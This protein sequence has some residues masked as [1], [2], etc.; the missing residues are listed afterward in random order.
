M[1]EAGHHGK[2]HKNFRDW[3]GPKAGQSLP[4][5]PEEPASSAVDS[6]KNTK[7]VQVTGD[8]LQQ[9]TELPTERIE[10]QSVQM[11][12]SE[13]AH[14]ATATTIDP[15]ELPT[16]L[17]S[18]QPR[19]G[20]ALGVDEP[21]PEPTSQSINP[22]VAQYGLSDTSES[23]HVVRVKGADELDEDASGSQSYAA[24]DRA[25][26]AQ[27]QIDCPHN[28]GVPQMVMGSTFLAL[29]ED[30]VP[31]NDSQTNQPP[32][33]EVVAPESVLQRALWL[34]ND[35]LQDAFDEYPRIMR[36]ICLGYAISIAGGGVVVA[37]QIKEGKIQVTQQTAEASTPKKPEPQPLPT[38]QSSAAPDYRNL[39]M[40]GPGEGVSHAIARQQAWREKAGLPIDPEPLSTIV[41]RLT[42]QLDRQTTSVA[43]V[44]V[45]QPNAT[46]VWA[47]YDETG[48]VVG[49]DIFPAGEA[50][51]V[52][53][54]DTRGQLELHENHNDSQPAVAVSLS[55]D[56]IQQPPADAPQPQTITSSPPAPPTAPQ[57]SNWFK[58]AWDW[59]SS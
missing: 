51:L 5:L 54:K 31:R 22:R 59:F 42:V 4:L 52:P 47:N 21:T 9:N 33:A 16:E 44:W 23:A 24:I 10:L 55:I 58:R 19:N 56:S 27:N 50:T 1:T 38:A 6:N 49:V 8:V 25:E 12:A 28:L 13:S 46:H 35:R 26:Q 30:P 14:Q 40:V 43:D 17:T 37:R 32:S 41:Q 7:P 36:A 18:V 2:R 48:H 34:V 20:G 39:T 53:V 3:F 15:T 45:S 57:S 29:E 11:P